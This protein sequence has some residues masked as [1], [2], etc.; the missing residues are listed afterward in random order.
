VGL[1][2]LYIVDDKIEELVGA[3]PDLIDA[4]TDW[5]QALPPALADA[6][7]D[8]RD[9][10]YQPMVDTSV[11]LIDDDYRS[12]T[13]VIE[14]VNRGD[15]VIT[16]LSMRVTVDD[17]EG[18]PTKEMTVYA[19]TPLTIDSDWRGPL[20][21]GST[22]RF[23]MRSSRL[24]R[25]ACSASLEVTELRVWTGEATLDDSEVD[26]S[27]AEQYGEIQLPERDAEP[28]STGAEP[29]Q[30]EDT[31]ADEESVEDNS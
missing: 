31:A 9:L 4:L 12:T 20:L 6:I 26:E 10:S 24:G 19:A 27:D 22:R 15:K 3:S 14:V 17:D 11:E 1:Y 30:D 8:R 7:D 2:G 18:I 16:L 21:P 29:S 13:P 28:E 5:Q 25:D 23:A